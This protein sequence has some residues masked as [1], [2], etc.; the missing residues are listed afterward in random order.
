VILSPAL[1]PAKQAVDNTEAAV[2]DPKAETEVAVPADDK[3]GERAEQIA[4]LAM[5]KSA[6]SVFI[7]R[8]ERVSADGPDQQDMRDLFNLLASI[9]RKLR[10]NADVGEMTKLFSKRLAENERLK[11]AWAYYRADR[12]KKEIAKED[13]RRRLELERRRQL[14]RQAAIRLR[15]KYP[16]GPATSDGKLGTVVAGLV[17]VNFAA[18]E[19]KYWVGTSGV[20]HHEIAQNTVMTE[21]LKD[22]IPAEA[23]PREACAEVD[24]MKRYIVAMGVTD[25]AQIDGSV[26]Y[27]HAETWDETKNRW[28][29]RGACGNCSQW[30]SAIGAEHGG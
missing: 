30:I 25:K 19:K 17:D 15:D 29:A 27:F 21:L 26:L 16:G 3:A 11:A 23:W 20:E 12:Q 4:K 24:T 7:D 9:E 18:T 28:K 22:V 1:A 13:E 6:V 14:A 2:L 10:D 8:V 5:Q